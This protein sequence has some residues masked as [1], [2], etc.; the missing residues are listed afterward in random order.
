MPSLEAIPVLVEPLDA[1]TGVVPALLG[2]LDDAL[3]SLLDRGT[4]HVID[5]S[6]MPMSAADRLALEQALGTGE[7]TMELSALGRS[8]IRE[9]SFPG[10]WWVR[11]DDPQGRTLA[12]HIEVA[13]VPEIVRAHGSDIERGRARLGTLIGRETSGRGT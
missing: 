8:Q 7:L 4:R 6:T 11:H 9:T 1:K 5:L 13:P 10:V 2:E 3:Q 12:E